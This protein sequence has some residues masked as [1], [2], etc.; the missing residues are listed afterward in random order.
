M[1]W[2]EKHPWMTFFM[3]VGAVLAAADVVRAL[4]STPVPQQPK[5]QPIPP[6]G[7]LNGMGMAA[8]VPLLEYALRT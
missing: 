8:N 7:V 3:G 1:S 4:Q 5:E 6:P 2:T